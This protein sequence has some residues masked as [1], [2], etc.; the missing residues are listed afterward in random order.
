MQVSQEEGQAF[1]NRYGMSAYHE[2]S[3]RSLDALQTLDSMF[4]A[5]AEAMIANRESMELTHSST[6]RSGIISLSTDWEILEM[7]DDLSVPDSVYSPQE[8]SIR[9]RA[10]QRPS[11]IKCLC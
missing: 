7:P 5:L 8:A 11:K 6:F 2:L 3:A 4:T 1:A 10:R 9:L